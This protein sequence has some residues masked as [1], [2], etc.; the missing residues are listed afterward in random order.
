MRRLA[1]T[2]ILLGTCATFGLGRKFYDD[3]PLIREPEPRSVKATPR[4]ISDYYDFFW[5]TLATPGQKQRIAEPIPAQGVNTL[6]DPIDR[7]WWERRHYWR[8]MSLSELQSGP[9]KGSAPAID[10]DWIIVSAK[11]EGI[12]PG[13]VVLDGKKRRY[14]VKFDPVSNPEMATGADKI[15]STIFYALGYHVPANHIVYF[16]PEMLK[17]S[18]GVTVEDRFGRKRKMTPEDLAAI[19][20]RVPRGSENRYRAT[21]SLAVPGKP[22]G[23]YRYF[24][25]RSD[26]PNDIVPHE[27]RRDLRGMHVAAALVGHDDSRSINTYDALVEGPSGTFVK[28]YQLDFGSTLGSGTHKSNTP[29][30]G[31]EYL[32]GWKQAGV[33]LF[34]LGLAVPRWAHANFPRLDSVGRFESRVFDPDKWVPEYPNP[35]FLNRLPDDEFWMAKQIVSLRDEDI[36]AIVATAR[37]SDP[38][39]TEW[40]AKCLIERR[41]KIGRAAFRKV[42]PIDRFELRDGRLEW[43]DLAAAYG[44]GAA[45]EIRV[46]WSAFDNERETAV[47]LRGEHSARLPEMRADGYWMATFDS[48]AR[49]NQTVQVYIRKRGER[50]QVIGVE[51]R[52]N[53]C[54][55]SA[56]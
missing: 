51:R 19:L 13:F 6:G 38:K 42:L 1:A 11:T 44:L 37:Y 4:K 52:W 45:L 31:G 20:S 17:L 18:P 50:M 47:P 26:D 28:H 43:V 48:P 32:F 5:H 24:G 33:Q 8:R 23:P 9:E 7:A 25:T 53:G 36:H 27:H 40:V 34:T 12:T 10:G 21:A 14:F 49:P 29:R 16:R 30:S 39:A 22:I 54:A 55:R 35:A 46:R 56:S 15:G 2:V 41:D 3:D